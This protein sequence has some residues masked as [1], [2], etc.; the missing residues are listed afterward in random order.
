MKR[1]VQPGS[2]EEEDIAASVLYGLIGGIFYS[3]DALIR[4]L[5]NYEDVEVVRGT[6]EEKAS[7]K[8]FTGLKIRMASGT[9]RVK[10]EREHR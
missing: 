3:H 9:Y 10:I 2:N 8:H 5:F 7:G 6:P 4:D 1:V